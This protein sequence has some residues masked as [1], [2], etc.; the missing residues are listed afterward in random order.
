MLR[1][2]RRDL[3]NGELIW[4]K[5]C[6][7]FLNFQL[8]FILSDSRYTLFHVVRI[9]GTDS[10]H[11]TLGDTS[12]HFSLKLFLLEQSWWFPAP[13]NVGENSGPHRTF[14]QDQMLVS[15]FIQ[16][17]DT[18]S[19]ITV[20][21]AYSAWLFAW[22]CKWL[23]RAGWWFG[24][25]AQMNEILVFHM[26]SLYSICHFQFANVSRPGPKYIPFM[27]PEISSIIN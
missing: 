14:S 27:F 23:C 10:T 2:E 12:A 20:C 16:S 22:F 8:C 6:S 11:F 17:T 13:R 26:S 1:C 9:M 4:M 15:L 25:G 19:P 24:K 21:K 5:A 7:L 3:G 18:Y